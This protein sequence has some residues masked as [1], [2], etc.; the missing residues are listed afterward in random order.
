MKLK[1]CIL[2]RPE[3]LLWDELFCKVEKQIFDF[4]NCF[5]L[6]ISIFKEKGLKTLFGLP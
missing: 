6:T 1:K 2:G 4:P 5:I 3:Y